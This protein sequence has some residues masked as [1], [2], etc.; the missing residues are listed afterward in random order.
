MIIVTESIVYIMQTNIDI[1]KRR[2]MSYTIGEVAEMM[3]VTPS[4]L[5]Y[6]DQEGLFP[7]VN[8]VNGIRVFEDKDFTWLRVLN[9]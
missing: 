8:R 9:C 7:E 4:T 3:G 6:Y 1:E 2:I 5:R